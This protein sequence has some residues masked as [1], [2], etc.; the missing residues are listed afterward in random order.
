MIRSLIFKF[1]FYLGIICICLIFSIA[2]FFPSKIVSFGGKLTGYWA[3]ICLKLLTRT[4]IEINGLQNI[5]K[6]KK[7]FIVCTHQSIFETFF[8][9]TLFNSPYFIIKKELIKIPLFGTFLRKIGCI[10][11]ERNKTSKENL[12]FFEKVIQSINKTDKP[13]IIF[14]QGSRFKTNERPEF[15]KG[16]SRIFNLNIACQPIVMNSGDIWPKN[17]NMSYNKK[18]IVSILKPIHPDLKNENF[19]SDLENLMY[20]ELSRIT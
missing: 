12:G 19:L 5:E 10:P 6:N 7:I 1:V 13:L 16:V 18:L 9:Q 20:K 14:P 8:L 11:I 4:K 15:K 2:L 17:G 3:I